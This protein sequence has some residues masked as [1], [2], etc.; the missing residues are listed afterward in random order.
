[1]LDLIAETLRSHGLKVIE[2]G[3]GEQALKT[4]L[5]NP[6]IDML[7]TDVEMPKM[8]GLQLVAQVRKRHRR[9][10]PA[11]VVSTRGS[12]DDK[13]AAMQVGAD[14]YLVKSD[15]SRESLWSLVSRFVD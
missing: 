5:D 12:D 7:V 13:Q 6:E 10:I 8:D 2:A 11:I 9:R 15:F 14:A 3:D 4:L 1:V